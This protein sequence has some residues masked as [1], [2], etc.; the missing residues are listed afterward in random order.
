MPARIEIR[1]GQ[2]FTDSRFTRRVVGL[3]ERNGAPRVVY[4]KGGDRLYQC[5]RE[6]FLRFRR[7]AVEVTDCSIV[8]PEEG[9]LLKEEG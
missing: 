1:E 7:H 5:G 6:Q 3:F 9:G 4:S 8:M 2:A